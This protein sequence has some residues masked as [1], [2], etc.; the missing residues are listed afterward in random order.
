M[1]H[2][3]ICKYKWIFIKVYHGCNSLVTQTDIDTDIDTD[4]HRH[5]HKN[6]DIDTDKDRC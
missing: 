5:R 6:R 3:H 4:R 2:A 1:K